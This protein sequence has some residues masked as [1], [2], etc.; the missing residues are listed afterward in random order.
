[1]TLKGIPR[2]PA[3]CTMS[4]PSSLFRKAQLGCCKQFWAVC[5]AYARSQI[6]F[7]MYYLKINYGWYRFLTKFNPTWWGVGVGR[8]LPFHKFRSLVSVFFVCHFMLERPFHADILNTIVGHSTFI[9][10]HTL[11]LDDNTIEE[12]WL[13]IYGN[14]KACSKILP[15]S[16]IRVCDSL[17][18]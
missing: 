11:F 17:H 14:H 4:I 15:F 10:N 16:S 13:I 2:C 8:M 5:M 18:S 9:V 6:G 12:S 3:F 1:M 7:F